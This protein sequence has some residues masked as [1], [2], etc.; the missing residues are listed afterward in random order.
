MRC[1]LSVAMSRTPKL[2]D[3]IRYYQ[4]SFALIDIIL[5]V[6]GKLIYWHYPYI[7]TP[8]CTHGNGA[9]VFFLVPNNQ[10]IMELLHTMLTDF[11]SYFF[12]AQFVNNPNA[13][14]T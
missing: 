5:Q 6:L 14:L 7:T 2:I 8:T 3:Q 12:T 9:G 10:Y 4:Q 13:S 11:T 1:F